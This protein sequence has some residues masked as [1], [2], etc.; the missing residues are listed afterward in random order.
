MELLTL[1][2]VHYL[3]LA[4]WSTL[5][6]LLGVVIAVSSIV[7]VHQI[8]RQVVVSVSGVM[9]AY[10]DD[11]SYLLDRPGLTMDDYF[12]LRRRWRDGGLPELTGMMP[13]VDGNVLTDDGTLR[14][15][16]VDGFSG[17]SAVTG[18]ALVP[19]GA[20]VTGPGEA[21]TGSSLALNGF[22]LSVAVV[23]ESVPARMVL[24]DIGTAQMVLGRDDLALDRIAVVMDAAHRRFET[25]GERFLPGLSAG[26]T[27]PAWSLPGWRVLPVD[28][29]LPELAFA[30]SVL[31]NLGALGCL[32]LVVAWLL[33]FQVGVIS[34][35]RRELTLLRLRQLGA[36]EGEL[37]RGFLVGLLGLAGVATAL[38]VWTGDLL[39]RALAQ[40]V[41]GYGTLQ[42]PVPTLD[43]WVVAK[44]L[45][46]ALLVCGVGG[47]VAFHR[48]RG[49]LPP[50][51]GRWLVPPGVLVAGGFGILGTQ[52]LLGGFVA[53]AAA[54][55]LVLLGI[56]PLLRLLNRYGS[57]VGGSLL[58]RS[59]VRE[60]VWY[61]GDLAVA[62]GALVLALATSIAIA[63]M[64]DSFRGDFER[65]LDQ[66]LAYDVFVDGDGRD[67]AALAESLAALPGVI[68][69]QAYGGQHVRLLGRQVAVSYS[70][71]DA[72]EGRR[73]G[74]DGPLPA[75]H[76]IV[77]ERL[78]RTLGAAP[79]DVV[80]ELGLTVAGIFPGFGDTTPRLLVGEADAVRLGVPVRY[81]RLSVDARDTAGV[82]R[83][84]EGSGGD[85]SVQEPGAVRSRALGV[86]DRT[87]RVTG[88]LTLLALMVAAVGLYNALLAMALLRQRMRALFDALGIST[89]ERRRVDAGRTFAIC[90]LVVLLAV[91]LGLVLGLLLCEVINP[92]AFGWSLTLAPGW[93]A[94]ARPVLVA[95]GV[96][97]VVA[98]L[99]VPVEAVP[100]AE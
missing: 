56:G 99:P 38:G 2:Q 14:L 40:A 47:A 76:C 100:D 17:V 41:T 87:F 65:M 12:E 27:P 28:V 43:G 7:A 69:V 67:L 34:L 57:R 18:L 85:L 81:D 92:R 55:L 48:E 32:A 83:F 39:A 60:L 66:R 24:T 91:P 11:V 4:P 3:R 70:R 29:E 33:V 35:R 49:G 15:I 77:S 52:S 45:I 31:F 96:C 89:A 68:R 71:I 8:S 90:L 9:P 94:V 23:H 26:F 58:F 1:S 51:V 88:A 95:L 20:V 44:A 80:E 25:W 78:A 50:R 98:L 37:L 36:T 97:A 10:L 79:G 30:R 86:F 46:S 61:P 84:L 13:L 21:A 19:P 42:A 63:T 74:L 16:G 22:V 75:G 53:V 62:V 93:E 5:T 73:Y 82:L 72:R 54:A 59:G 64:V 6:V